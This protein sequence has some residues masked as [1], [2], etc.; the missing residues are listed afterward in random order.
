MSNRKKNNRIMGLAGRMVL[1]AFLTLF[2]LTTVFPQVDAAR[3]QH[4]NY[5]WR[6]VT[7]ATCTSKGTEKKWCK[8]CDA[9]VESREIP[10]LKHDPKTIVV[11]A[12]CTAAGYEETSCK[13]CNKVINRKDFDPLGHYYG[14]WVVTKE[15][16]C[17]ATGERYHI[18]T[19]C[20]K[21]ETQPIEKDVNKHNF[22]TEG[23][24]PT[25]TEKGYSCKRC[26]WCG[27]ETQRKDIDA[28]GHY[29]SAWTVTKVATC[30]ATGERYHTCT[31]CNNIET[32]T[33]EKDT[34]NHSYG[35]WKTTKE[36]TCKV[37]G[38]K[39]RT[40]TRCGH[41]DTETI[42]AT[43]HAYTWVRQDPTCTE[44]GYSVKQCTKCGKVNQ[45]WEI[46]PL[47]HDYSD[48]TVTKQPTC[49]GDGE[50]THTCTRCGHTETETINHLG[51]AYTWEKHY[52]TCTEGGYSAKQCDRCGKVAQRYELD[53]LGHDCS[54]WTVTK[55]ATC[56]ETGLK[57]STCT[58]CC[59]TITE[60]IDALG[61]DLDCYGKCSRCSYQSAA[62]YKA[63]SKYLY[64]L[65][66]SLAKG[67]SIPAEMEINGEF[68]SNIN[69]YSFS[70]S[71]MP[72]GTGYF[73]FRPPEGYLQNSL[74]GGRGESIYYFFV[75]PVDK[76]DSSD[77]G[78]FDP[79]YIPDPTGNDYVTSQY[80][81][82][83]MQVTA[84]L[85][86]ENTTHD[87]LNYSFNVERQ[88][89]IV[90]TP[91]QMTSYGTTKGIVSLRQTAY[92]IFPVVTTEFKSDSDY[93][94]TKLERLFNPGSISIDSKKLVD[95]IE[96][97]AN[98]VFACFHARSG[99]WLGFAEI[100]F[101]EVMKNLNGTDWDLKERE[102]IEE[103]KKAAKKAGVPE[104][105]I[106]EEVNQMM[107]WIEFYDEN[108]M[109]TLGN[110]SGIKCLYLQP[111]QLLTGAGAKVNWKLEIGCEINP[112][113]NVP[114][115]VNISS[116][117]FTDF[118][119]VPNNGTVR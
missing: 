37:D 84:A 83:V 49:K 76:P 19:R 51:H 100:A 82:D 119:G 21:K 18:C 74:K 55:E 80:A 102:R 59:E 42:S 41:V 63:N 3:C 48:W 54:D 22:E 112:S 28:L 91:V 65:C 40:C 88:F 69:A 34:N 26:T 24:N 68:L 1:A 94:I 111:K 11:N 12:T 58:R 38:E 66:E 9:Y 31:R 86:Y 46:D 45:R 92:S 70:S 79:I 32:E 7:A 81:W 23:K 73:E 90:Y 29:Y 75:N 61:H 62:D 96:T 67:G 99:D 110:P 87:E 89:R 97:V 4:S 16:T 103:Y 20:P 17:S 117:Y 85:N 27:K 113:G 33:I 108:D 118:P 39:T 93:Y 101:A 25:C 30:T 2:A 105:E 13:R 109:S 36:P 116:F 5:E 56:T 114:E 57:T 52:P 35:N 44:G 47:G 98:V 50:K 77:P 95:G 106:E 107:E 43:G 15:A 10:K 104:D 8:D 71:F 53:P 78:I 60:T 14:A 6:T 64:K 115:Q 72:F